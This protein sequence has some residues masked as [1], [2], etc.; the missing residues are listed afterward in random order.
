MI[1]HLILAYFFIALLSVTVCAQEINKEKDAIEAVI[2]KLFDGMRAGDSTMVAE[3]FVPDAGMNSVYTNREG[4]VVVASSELQA[5]L[6]TVGTPHQQVY[7]ERITEY[8]IRID[9]DLASVWTPYQFYVGDQ[10]SH[11]GVNS[12][13]MAKLNGEWKIIY[14]VDTRRRDNCID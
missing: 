11:C 12:F 13:Q 9:A 4:K 8:T 10:F 7:D 5:F 2:T 1:R 14:I 6:T 3:T